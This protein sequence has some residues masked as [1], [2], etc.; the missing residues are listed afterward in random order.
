VTPTSPLGIRFLEAF[1]WGVLCG[2]A[3]AISG[4]TGL[5]LASNWYPQRYTNLPI[6]VLLIPLGGLIVGFG[7]AATA[8]LTRPRW[9]ATQM[10]LLVAL[11]TIGYGTFMVNAG[12]N[13]ATPAHLTVSLAPDPV[14]AMPCDAAACPPAAPPLQWMAQGSL[15]LQETERLGGTVDA[16]EVTSY[17]YRGGR[18]VQGS[19]QG[20]HVRYTAAQIGGPHHIRPNEIAS[21]PFRYSYRTDDGDSRRRVYVVIQFTGGA[22]HQTTGTGYWTVQ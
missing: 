1:G 10:G 22:G 6:Q 8:R 13:N 17:S 11:L 7:L 15:R 21:Y 14:T 20:P 5:V 12:R 19:M 9:T 16:I 2:P 3:L 4:L 18:F